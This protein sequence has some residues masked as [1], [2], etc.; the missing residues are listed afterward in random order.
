MQSL[1][2]RSDPA[3][4]SIVFLRP[5]TESCG[6]PDSQAVRNNPNRKN[7]GNG[8]KS[9]GCEIG[10]EKS[11]LSWRIYVEY[12][13]FIFNAL[14]RLMQAPETSFRILGQFLLI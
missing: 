13:C 4:P 9:A 14:R 12:M 7:P 2:G 11:S 6:L 3:D 10:T 1:S 8:T 5:Q